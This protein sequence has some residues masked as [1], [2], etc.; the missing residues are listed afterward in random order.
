MPCTACSVISIDDNW[1]VQCEKFTLGAYMSN[2]MAL[3][4]A[5]REQLDSTGEGGVQEIQF[6]TGLVISVLNIDFATMP[7]KSACIRCT[8]EPCGASV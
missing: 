6:R 8:F 2:G 3:R 7:K 5:T 1:I 4:L